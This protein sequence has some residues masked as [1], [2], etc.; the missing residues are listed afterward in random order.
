[1]VSSADLPLDGDEQ[2]RG[3]VPNLAKLLPK[4]LGAGFWPGTS[5][6]PS[7]RRLTASHQWSRFLDLQRMRASLT[8]AAP[9]ASR[10][11]G[12]GSLLQSTATLGD[13]QIQSGT[14]RLM[15]N[16]GNRDGVRIWKAIAWT[17]PGQVLDL[18]PDSAAKEHSQTKKEAEEKTSQG[19]REA[20]SQ[21][22]DD[23]GQWG[24]DGQAWASGASPTEDQ[25]PRS[26]INLV[27]S[28]A[29]HDPEARRK[30][31]EDAW[32]RVIEKGRGAAEEIV[33]P[34]TE[35]E[36]TRSSCRSLPFVQKISHPDCESLTMQNQLCFGQ[37]RSFFVPG[38]GPRLNHSCSRC[39]PSQLRKTVVLLECEGG[40]TV[41]KDVVL[42]EGCQ[43]DLQK[44]LMDH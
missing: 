6:R 17:R 21:P 33:L 16:R 22:V 4:P 44:D 34:L 24:S 41:N 27:P 15:V 28:P 32:R 36:V 23:P 5:S 39:S 20:S 35:Y 12:F 40:R 11:L 14:S 10:T 29:K 37:C 30:M 8:K 26:N 38:A 13:V 7:P 31:A 43:C 1:M 3:G 9:S 2:D 18:S 42:V 19:R 25:A